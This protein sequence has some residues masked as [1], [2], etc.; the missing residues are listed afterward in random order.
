MSPEFVAQFLTTIL[1]MVGIMVV[2]MRL[3]VNRYGQGN[4]AM[5]IALDNSRQMNEWRNE[6]WAEL[7]TERI[8]RAEERG[9]HQAQYEHL[10]TELEAERKKNQE[11]DDRLKHANEE[12]AAELQKFK[13]DSQAKIDRLTEEINSLR[14]EQ[15]KIRDKL[16]NTIEER[17]QL[18]S[19][20]DSLKTNLASLEEQIDAKIKAAVDKAV[21]ELRHEY[22]GKLETLNQQIREK[23]IEIARLSALIE[24]IKANEK[25][26]SESV[27]DHGAGGD[28]AD[29][30]SST[31]PDPG[32]NAD[33]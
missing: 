27:E 20:R 32:H 33:T 8:G 18:V 15:D 22:E 4:E 9:R 25:I 28:A 24:E 11:L 19:E 16:N 31:S 14:S 6:L 12:N 21:A 3:M 2:F 7:K 29:A 30:Q 10:K 23:D 1:T 5:S 17:D 13:N 26:E